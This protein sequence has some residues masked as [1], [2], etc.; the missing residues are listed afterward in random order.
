V[1]Q[2]IGHGE[3]TILNEEIGVHLHGLEHLP[4]A[5]ET[6]ENIFPESSISDVLEELREMDR[7]LLDPISLIRPELRPTGEEASA[8]AVDE[9]T[10]STVAVDGVVI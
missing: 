1:I 3:T 9:A 6:R 5:G 10:G 8:A 2:G 7:L 4:K